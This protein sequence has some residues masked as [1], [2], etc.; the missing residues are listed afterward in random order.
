L[1]RYIIIWC[2]LRRNRFCI[3]VSVRSDQGN[4]MVRRNDG[5]SVD[6]PGRSGHVCYHRGARGGLGVGPDSLLGRTKLSALR[7]NG[8]RLDVYGSVISKVV[9]LLSRDDSGGIC[10]RYEFIGIP[11]NGWGCESRFV[12]NVLDIDILLLVSYDGKLGAK[13][14]LNMC[15]NFLIVS[16]NPQN[17]A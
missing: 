9:D 11:Y 5:R 7:S 12:A 13:D 2:V 14:F 1:L 4:Q 8:P 15:V 6:I 10:P 3:R 17:V 16:S